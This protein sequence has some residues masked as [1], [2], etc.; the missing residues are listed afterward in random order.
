M[1]RK[2][3][4]SQASTLFKEAC[5]CY[6]NE[7]EYF[8]Y[9]GWAMYLS[10]PRAHGRV[11]LARNLLVKARKLAPSSDKPYLF[12]GRLYKAEG[13]DGVAEK[14]FQKV[15]EL[16]PD[17]VDAIRELRLIDMRRQRSKGLVR[18]ILRR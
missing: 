13:K 17:C 7:G 12:L 10:D 18:R 14:M 9:Y 1:L 15:I 8:A 16:D 6:P 3:S 11:E 2:K 4:Y 5:E